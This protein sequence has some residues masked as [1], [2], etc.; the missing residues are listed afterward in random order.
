MPRVLLL[1]SDKVLAHIVTRAL[2]Q[3]GYDFDHATDPQ[4]AISLADANTP[5][6]VLMDLMLANR[7]G[8]EFLYEFVSYPEW[9][10]VPI[11]LLASVPETEVNVGGEGF[12]QLNIKKYLYKPHS[13]ITQIVEAVKY[14]ANTAL[15]E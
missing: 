1:E 3:A 13:S 9:Q 12:S 5:D 11:V 4:G 2:H 10:S 6:V 7:S 14:A 15:T 8:I